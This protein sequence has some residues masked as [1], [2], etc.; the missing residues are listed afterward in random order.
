MV[1]GSTAIEGLSDYYRAWVGFCAGMLRLSLSC[2]L[3]DDNCGAKAIAAAPPSC[4]QDL[5]RHPD[6]GADVASLTHF[7]SIFN[8]FPTSATQG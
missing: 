8:A 4:A 5:L 7:S 6:R 2:A 1:N 3:N